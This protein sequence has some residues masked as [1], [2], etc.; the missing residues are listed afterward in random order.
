MKMNLAKLFFAFLLLA[1]VSG[2]AYNGKNAV[3]YIGASDALAQ[4][5]VR[6][7]RVVVKSSELEGSLL[8]VDVV[9][10]M[11]RNPDG[12][13]VVDPQTGQPVV[14]RLIR[15]ARTTPFGGQVLVN[16]I[17]GVA[18]AVVQGEYGKQIAS[19]GACKGDI[20]NSTVIL[21]EG[22][23]AAALS[24]SES[25]ASSSANVSGCSGPSCLGSA[26]AQ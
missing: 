17:P 19:E 14:T 16:T 24:G 7:D 23:Q 3:A 26:F 20:C 25:N 2:C 15:E 12:S 5:D 4:P 21:N 6:V 9:Q 18:T 13:F 10:A 11:M 8:E 22:S 1:F